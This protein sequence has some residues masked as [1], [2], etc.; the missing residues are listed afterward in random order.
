MRSW[1]GKG[2]KIV[3]LLGVGVGW[4]KWGLEIQKRNFIAVKTRRLWRKYIIKV[5]YSLFHEERNHPILQKK[6]KCTRKI[7]MLL[8][9]SWYRNSMDKDWESSRKCSMR[10]RTSSRD[11]CKQFKDSSKKDISKDRKSSTGRRSTTSTLQNQNSHPKP[12]SW[13]PKRTTSQHYRIHQ[14]TP[15]HPNR[16]FQ[17]THENTTSHNSSQQNQ[18]HSSTSPKNPNMTYSSKRSP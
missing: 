16:P 18:S 6:K 12:V 4:G 7:N 3:G 5:N 8:L 11:N 2:R 10:W 13:K 14:A 15:P 1:K 9:S 17:R